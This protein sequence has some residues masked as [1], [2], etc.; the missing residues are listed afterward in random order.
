[1][2]PIFSG[3]CN[4]LGMKWRLGRPYGFLSIEGSLQ[5]RF[6]QTEDG[7]QI[8]ASIACYLPGRISQHSYR[9]LLVI[10]GTLLLYRVLVMIQDSENVFG[11]NPIHG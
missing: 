5:G 1:V 3:S 6:M 7:L 4:P 9:S 8:H 2:R 11:S 10:L